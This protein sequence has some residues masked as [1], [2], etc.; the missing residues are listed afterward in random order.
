MIAVAGHRPEDVLR[1]GPSMRYPAAPEGMEAPYGV[2][3]RSHVLGEDAHVL[4]EWCVAGS[5]AFQTRASNS[6]HPVQLADM[7]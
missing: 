6:R 7:T 1:V 4:G 5:E 2:G 3:P